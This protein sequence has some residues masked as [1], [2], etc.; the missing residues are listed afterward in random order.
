[1]HQI[2]HRGIEIQLLVSPSIWAQN[3]PDI[4]NFLLSRTIAR[5][6]NDSFIASGELNHTLYIYMILLLY[7]YLYYILCT[8]YL[9]FLNKFIVL[10][11]LYI[12]FIILI[13]HCISLI[14]LNLLVLFNRT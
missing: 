11:Y 12:T 3:N 7:S 14:L 10:I 13:V 2:L 4:F 9:T 6:S 1:M 8:S 5:N